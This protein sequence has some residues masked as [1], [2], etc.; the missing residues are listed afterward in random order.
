[1]TP[2]QPL[3]EAFF[4]LFRPTA[5]VHPPQAGRGATRQAPATTDQYRRARTDPAC[6]DAFRTC[7]PGSAPVKSLASQN[8]WCDIGRRHMQWPGFYEVYRVQ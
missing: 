1:M 5:S 7:A 8:I 3:L 6:R 2:E 4:L